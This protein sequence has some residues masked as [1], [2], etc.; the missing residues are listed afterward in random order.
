MQREHSGP[1]SQ[2]TWG[3][4]LH[5]AAEI[6][7]STELPERPAALVPSARVRGVQP[8]RPCSRAG[9][10]SPGHR[11]S[12]EVDGLRPRNQPRGKDCAAP[13]PSLNIPRTCRLGVL[14]EGL[15]PSPG[16]LVAALGR[17]RR[18]SSKDRKVAGR[19]EPALLRPR[20]KPQMPATPAIRDLRAPLTGEAPEQRGTRNLP[21]SDRPGL[22]A[23]GL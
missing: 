14:Q 11:T 9:P 3:P 8:L 12:A 5:S 17:G 10:G 7:E 1:E 23:V 22:W 2:A 20:E 18:L 15:C 16:A 4:Q 19:G 6:H 13:A 21:G